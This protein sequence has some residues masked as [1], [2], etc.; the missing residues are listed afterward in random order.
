[1]DL[2]ATMCSGD[3]CRWRRCVH[4]WVCILHWLVQSVCGGNMWF[5]CVCICKDPFHPINWFSF[6]FIAKVQGEKFVC[7]CKDMIRTS[8]RWSR[9]GSHRIL[10][11]K[12]S[13]RSNV[14]RDWRFCGLLPRVHGW[15]ITEIRSQF[16]HIQIWICCS[17]IY[18]VQYLSWQG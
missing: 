16:V 6:F 5:L 3:I 15:K 10:L 17:Y 2:L 18:R 12:N 1:M 14:S 11:E 7:V 13:P 4:C 8:I 9:R